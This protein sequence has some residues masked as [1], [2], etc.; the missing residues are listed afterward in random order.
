M[1]KHSTT[2]IKKIAKIR[3]VNFIARN[4]KRS[5]STIIKFIL[6]S[7]IKLLSYLMNGHFYMSIPLN[8]NSKLI[9][10]TNR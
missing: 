9:R 1:N 5:V 6:S 8:L 2:A 4:A 7:M 10:A 3:I